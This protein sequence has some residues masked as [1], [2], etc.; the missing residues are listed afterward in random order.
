V[1]TEDGEPPVWPMRNIDFGFEDAPDEIFDYGDFDNP[2]D[3]FIIGK[4]DIYGDEDEAIN[5]TENSMEGL[6]DYA[7]ENDEYL[8][9]DLDTDPTIREFEYGDMDDPNN[10]T[11]DVYQDL[12]GNEDASANAAENIIT[13]IDD[14]LNLDDDY[15]YILSYIDNRRSKNVKI[16]EFGNEDVDDEGFITERK[17]EGILEYEY[18]EITSTNK[19]EEDFVE[20]DAGIKNVGLYFD[21][22]KYAS[23]SEITRNTSAII[24]YGETNVKELTAMIS[25]MA[26]FRNRDTIERYI[27]N[28]FNNKLESMAYILNKFRSGGDAYVESTINYQENIYTNNMYFWY[29]EIDPF[30]WEDFSGNKIRK[31][32]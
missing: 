22:T 29:N 14:Y 24:G 1:Y 20:S 30:C 25:D 2:G 11:V 8:L 28:I 13:G 12:Y 31:A 16:Y 19:V 3:S 4:R 7:N 23:D 27:Q 26:I 18:G 15:S 10:T 6:D 17:T 32:T 9:L 5:S 21:Y